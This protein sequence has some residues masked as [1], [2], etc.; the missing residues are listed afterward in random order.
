M[1]CSTAARCASA[2]TSAAARAAFQP[3]M[4]PV[5]RASASSSAEW[6]GSGAG[7]AGGAASGASKSSAYRMPPNGRGAGRAG[8]EVRVLD[9]G[10]HG[11]MVLQGGAHGVAQQRVHAARAPVWV[12]GP[13][14]GQYSSSSS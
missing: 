5:S 6:V 1:A 8:R 7:A 4:R 3:S 14:G 12:F 11:G 13:A 10:E 2:S 9:A